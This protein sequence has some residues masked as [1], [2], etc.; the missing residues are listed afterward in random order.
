MSKQWDKIFTLLFIKTI[1]FKNKL[2]I[3]STAYLR[4]NENHGDIHLM[5]KKIFFFNF[6]A[7]PV[8]EQRDYNVRRNRKTLPECIHPNDCCSLQFRTRSAIRFILIGLFSWN[9]FGTSCNC[10][11][12]YLKR[13]LR[14]C[15][16]FTVPTYLQLILRLPNLAG[17]PEYLR[18]WLIPETIQ[19]LIYRYV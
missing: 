3:N 15:C 2:A 19:Y 10:F 16:Y 17:L 4:S 6:L 13:H 1:L 7:I 5:K 8:N 14:N 11:Q 9:H 18:L 12:S